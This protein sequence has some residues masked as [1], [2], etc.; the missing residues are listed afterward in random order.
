[1]SARRAAGPALAAAGL[2]AACASFVALALD[3]PWLR[4][5]AKPLPALL[6][7]AWVAPRGRDRPGRLVS[8]GLVLSAAGD[9]LLE[10]GHFL[11]G[12]ASFLLAH[13]AYLWAFVST[14]R[15]PAIVRALPFAAW[16]TGTLVALRH[17]LGAMALPVGLYV[18]V[19]CTM[20]WRASA[21]LGGRTA[22]RAAWL[23]LAGAVA[24]AASDTIIAFDRFS[25]PIPRARWAIM[26]L[27][28]LGQW[29]IAASAAIGRPPGNGMLQNR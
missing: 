6:L 22:R 2:L 27:Y 14:D 5:A 29:G 23:G 8:A 20:M 26:V 4:L 10:L 3:V 1:M 24:F 25:A 13:V 11:P 28:W 21:R 9:A 17:G 18:T 19:I 15:R 7:A 12:L 16:G